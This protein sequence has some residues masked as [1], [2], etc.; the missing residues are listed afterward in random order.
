MLFAKT[1]TKLYSWNGFPTRRNQVRVYSCP[2]SSP[3]YVCASINC[4][5]LPPLSADHLTNTTY[6]R[7]EVLAVVKVWIVIFWWVTPCSGHQPLAQRIASML[8]CRHYSSEDYSRHLTRFSKQIVGDK[9]P[10]Q[11]V[12]CSC[13]CINNQRPVLQLG[14]A[15]KIRLPA[16]D[17]LARNTAI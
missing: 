16:S 2:N 1:S 9:I 10:P 14:A 6:I 8:E 12:S 13:K 7:S 17:V 11:V 4:G 3:M 15:V 5:R